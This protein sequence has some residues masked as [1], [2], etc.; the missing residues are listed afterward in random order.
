M[1][2]VKVGMISLGRIVR[3]NNHYNGTTFSRLFVPGQSVRSYYIDMQTRTRM[4]T[5]IKC[6][7]ATA[8]EF[9]FFILKFNLIPRLNK[10]YDISFK[11]VMRAIVA[12]RAI[13]IGRLQKNLTPRAF[14]P[15][16]RAPSRPTQGI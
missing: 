16:I 4:C 8:D 9:I 14:P 5:V 13:C 6:A 15:S 11:T 10:F 1:N 2:V 12:T 7:F 3:G